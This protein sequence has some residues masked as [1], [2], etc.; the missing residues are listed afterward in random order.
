MRWR[1]MAAMAVCCP[2]GVKRDALV[3]AVVDEAA[4]G[5]PLHGGGDGAGGEAEHVGERAGVRLGAVSGQA[6][7]GLEGLSFGLRE[8]VVHQL[9]Q[10][11]FG[12]P[13]SW[14]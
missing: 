8:G 13:K 1:R 11:V 7:D 9:V 5:E 2:S 10:S 12:P 6:V 14:L 3:G 4:V